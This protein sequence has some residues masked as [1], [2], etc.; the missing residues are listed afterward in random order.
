MLEKVGKD[1]EFVNKMLSDWMDGR[2]DKD[3]DG[4]LNYKEFVQF[5]TGEK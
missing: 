5:I 2:M 4:K 3:S 1:E